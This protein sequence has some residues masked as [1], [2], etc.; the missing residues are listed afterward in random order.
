MHERYHLD[1][2]PPGRRQYLVRDGR[3][4][5]ASSAA[6]GEPLSSGQPMSSN[7][8]SELRAEVSP[9]AVMVNAAG[10]KAP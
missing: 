6:A 2:H 10:A 3:R 1:C 9:V 7:V 8:A 5:G 4:L